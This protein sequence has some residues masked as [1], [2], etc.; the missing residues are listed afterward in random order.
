MAELHSLPT[1]TLVLILQF[2]GVIDLQSTLIAQRVSRRFRGIIQDAVL[3]HYPHYLSKAGIAG[4][5]ETV[6]EIGTKINPLWQYKFKSLF[7]SADCF[8]P[9]E[10][11]R[12]WV[13]TLDG[14]ATLPFR[15]LPWAAASDPLCREAFLRPEASW[16][17][18]SCTFGSS[19][20]IRCLDIVKSFDTDTGTPVTYSQV[21]LPAS[22]LTMGL[23]YDIL[24]CE[25]TLY[26]PETGSW[27]L[28]VGK[29]LKSFDVLYR[30]GCFIIDQP[31][32]SH[33]V[34][35]VEGGAILYVRGGGG[36]SKT[37]LGKQEWIPKR[38]EGTRPR[39]LPWQGP[40]LDP[41]QTEWFQ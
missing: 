6:I 7:N 36:C 5:T 17:G 14:D 23:L 16:R 30:W 1:E 9:S 27:E 34:C 33:L 12:Y 20:P 26:G 13:L 38:L 31:G 29:S 8:T 35:E 2:L 4:T 3:Y 18:L 21:E 24:L 28:L 37:V 39:F 19:P 10:R 25:E 22:G 40:L 32:E 15:R 11:A 41:T